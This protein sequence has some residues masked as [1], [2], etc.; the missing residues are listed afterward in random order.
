MGAVGDIDIVNFKRAE[1]FGSGRPTDSVRQ[2]V[3][4]DKEKDRDGILRQALYTLS[5]FPLLCLAGVSALV[6][7]TA[8]E[9]KVYPVSQGIVYQPVKGRQ[10]V[11]EAG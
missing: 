5:K 6:G 2:V 3:V 7:I 11:K 9:D 4:A 10:E 1:D 8:E